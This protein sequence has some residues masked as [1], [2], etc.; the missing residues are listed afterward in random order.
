MSIGRTN[1]P[2]ENT[3]IAIFYMVHYWNNTEMCRSKVK[4]NPCLIADL[5]PKR[6]NAQ[7]LTPLYGFGAIL[8]V[9]FR[10]ER[11]CFSGGILY[12]QPFKSR[13][14]SLPGNKKAPY[15]YDAFVLLGRWGKGT[16]FN[17]LLY[18][19]FLLTIVV[20]IAAPPLMNNRAIHSA[21]LLVSPVWGSLESSF[22]FAVTVSAFL[23]SFVPSLSL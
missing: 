4:C 2:I 12:R 20:P 17:Y 1:L 6:R 19:F 13:C 8:G 21:R 11:L 18:F 14:L 10:Y 7:N 9:F 15:R 23:I 22:S 5:L 3:K 16:L